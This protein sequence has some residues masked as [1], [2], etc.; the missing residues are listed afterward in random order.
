M[1]VPPKNMRQGIYWVQRHLKDQRSAQAAH[2]KQL[3]VDAWNH[4]VLNLYG[5]LQ[6]EIIPLLMKDA[7][8]MACE[9]RGKLTKM[10]NE[11]CDVS[12]RVTQT[13]RVTKAGLAKQSDRLVNMAVNSIATALDR[14]CLAGKKRIAW[15][16]NSK[17]L[18]VSDKAYMHV[19]YS[20][21]SPYALDMTGA[22]SNSCQ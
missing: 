21:M 16:T 9:D 1:H 11:F 8:F 5:K 6:S 12:D 10:V 18:Y 2:N 4:V 22:E 15:D 19:P 20:T 17:T 13:N 14:G 3:L 7:D